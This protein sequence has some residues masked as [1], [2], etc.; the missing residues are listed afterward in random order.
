MNLKNVFIAFY[1]KYF[2][3]KSIDEVVLDFK[4]FWRQKIVD[5]FIQV[6]VGIQLFRC[7][8]YKCVL[9]KLVAK[10]AFQSYCYHCL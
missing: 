6:K 3:V 1:R 4:V 2:F 8:K 7:C 5:A 10:A 9:K